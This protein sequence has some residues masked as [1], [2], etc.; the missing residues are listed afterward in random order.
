[1]FMLAAFIA[2]EVIK[3]VSPFLHK[4]LIPLTHAPI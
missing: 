3:R 4:P 2:F 1:M